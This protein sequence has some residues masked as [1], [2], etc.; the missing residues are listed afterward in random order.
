MQWMVFWNPAPVRN[1]PGLPGNVKVDIPGTRF[2]EARSVNSS[3]SHWDVNHS[4]DV[5]FKNNSCS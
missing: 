2:D 4:A 5:P 1:Q 3:L